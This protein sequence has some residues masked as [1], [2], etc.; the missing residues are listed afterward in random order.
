MLALCLL[1]LVRPAWSAGDAVILMYHNVSES[2][3]ES[4]SV[5]PATFERHMQY[6]ADNGFTVWPLFKT[7][8]HLASGKP[9]PEKTVVLTFD[10]AY[11]SVYTNAYP[12]LKEKGWPFTVF[13]TTMYI[14]DGYN[15]YMSWA[16]L[17]EIRQHGGDVG[18]HSRSHVHL[19]RKRGGETDEQWRTRITSEIE[20]A[21]AV[22]R[23]HVDD[24]V[25]AVAYPYGEYSK[26]VR[27]LLWELGYFGLGQQSGAV[28]RESDFQAIPRYPIATGFDDMDNFAIKVSSKALPVMVLSPE[29][30]VLDP[31][32]D[33]PVLTMR[34]LEG[35]YS[36][37]TLACY[38]SGQGRIQ[39]EWLDRELGVVQVRANEPVPPG[40]AKYN[41][42][43]RSG[44]GNNVFYWYSYLWMKPR[45]D[46]SWYRD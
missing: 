20:G 6:L 8:L 18:N 16:Q 39:H 34:L 26:E 7:L 33:I 10:D 31:G 36:K 29:D 21:Q 15:N 37:G 5:T 32:T 1:C 9:V 25:L 4:T 11:T 45:E 44:S 3:P 42:T 46:G 30:G 14:A 40:R 22:L 38:A 23:R 12:V 28:G 24:P 35:D 19:V 43:A 27:D 2:T 17:R 41:C 13:V